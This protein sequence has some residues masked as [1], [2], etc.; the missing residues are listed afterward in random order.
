[1]EVPE[2]FLLRV[3]LQEFSLLQQVLQRLIPLFPPVDI[4]ATFVFLLQL[5]QNPLCAMIDY[6]LLLNPL[7]IPCAF[8]RVT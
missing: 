6:L 7:Y 3:F 1:L 4:L 2:S 8:A 5:S